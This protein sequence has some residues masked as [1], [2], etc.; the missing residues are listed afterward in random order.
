MKKS[1]CIFLVTLVFSF[2]SGVVYGDSCYEYEY[3]ELKTMNFNELSSLVDDYCTT[4]YDYELLLMGGLL[5]GGR[6]SAYY[7]R[8]LSHCET[9]VKRVLRLMNE[10][11]EMKE[12]FYEYVFDQD[13]CYR[14]ELR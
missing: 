14:K 6:N 8:E 13:E 1:S 11:D 2:S 5:R 10:T 12:Q 3:A 7:D 4:I 9:Q